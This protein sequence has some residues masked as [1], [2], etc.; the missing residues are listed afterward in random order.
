M[1]DTQR[2]IT[3]KLS[4]PLNHFF[5]TNRLVVVHFYST[6]KYIDLKQDIFTLDIYV[7]QYIVNILNEYNDCTVIIAIIYQNKGVR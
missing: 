5:L 6:S 1:S 3:K 7:I 2:S 4:R